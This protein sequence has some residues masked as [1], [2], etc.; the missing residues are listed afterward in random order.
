VAGL[1]GGAVVTALRGV[2]CRLPGLILRANPAD[3][4][5]GQKKWCWRADREAERSYLNLAHRQRG[6]L[7]AVDTA[8][9]PGASAVLLDDGFF[10]CP[11]PPEGS[12]L[13][14]R[15]SLDLS[16]FAGAKTALT[17]ARQLSRF[18]QLHIATHFTFVAQQ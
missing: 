3:V 6:G 12:Y 5:G 4:R 10:A 16:L 15:G 7:R 13:P 18:V 17:N 14:F 9:L 11:D 1:I 2:W 8:H